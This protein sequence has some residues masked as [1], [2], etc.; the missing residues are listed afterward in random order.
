MP[1]DNTDSW[2]SV[3]WTPPEKISRLNAQI[4]AK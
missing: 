3:A 4:G 1:F 2:V